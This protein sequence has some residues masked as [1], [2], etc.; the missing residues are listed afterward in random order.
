MTRITR[1]LEYYK[2]FLD[3]NCPT[4]TVRRKAASSFLDVVK[5]TLDHDTDEVL[6]IIWSFF[7]T[8]SDLLLINSR[9]LR[10]CESLDVQARFKVSLFFNT[11]RLALLGRDVGDP[12]VMDVALVHL[13]LK[14][15]PLIRFL[16]QK[17][18]IVAAKNADN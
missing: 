3:D 7:V 10:G 5:Y 4:T 8:N 6:D 15:N 16:Q 13:R 12:R 11:F 14:S 9:G 17:A 18:K 2:Y 1:L